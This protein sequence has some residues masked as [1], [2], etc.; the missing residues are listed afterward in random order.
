VSAA[1]LVLPPLSPVLVGRPYASVP[2]LAA[3]VD[4]HTGVRLGQRDLNRDFIMSLLRPDG[5]ALDVVDRDAAADDPAAVADRALR[6]AMID[7]IRMG[8]ATADTVAATARDIPFRR[9]LFAAAG[10]PPEDAPLELA[11]VLEL[12]ATARSPLLDFYRE[13]YADVGPLR[14][15][16]ISVPFPGQ[17]L[18]ALLLA[19]HLEA[20]GTDL[21]VMGGPTISLMPEASLERLLTASAVDAV[22]L[23]EG[24][25]ALARLVELGGHDA[26]LLATVPALVYRT[27][28]GVRRNPPGE[29]VTLAATRPHDL[30]GAYVRG[31]VEHPV[32]VGRGCMYECAFCD[33]IHLYD[34]VNFRPARDVVEAA[35]RVVEQTGNAACHF[36]FEV[37]T[38]PYLRL[39]A[40]SLVDA[41]V[42]CTWRGFQRVYGDLTHDDVRA[43][44]ASGCVRLDV[45]LESADGPTL[46]LMNKGYGVDEIERFFTAFQGSSI[47]LLVNIILDYPGLTFEA[48]VEA[49]E[50]LS[51]VTAQVP[52]VHFELMRYSLSVT[53]VMYEEP[54]R[55]GL[56]IRRADGSK[57]LAS[58]TTASF[59]AERGMSAAEVA[60][61]EAR[62]R[63]LNQD[64]RVRLAAAAAGDLER[65][66]REGVGRFVVGRRPFVVAQDP[67][68]ATT[69]L[70][71]NL[72]T[73]ET[74]A[75]DESLQGSLSALQRD[76]PI[77]GDVR[78]LP[79]LVGDDDPDVLR[80]LTEMGMVEPERRRPGTDGIRVGRA[81]DGAFYRG[82]SRRRDGVA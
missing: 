8:T 58:L 56:A 80:S 62:Y 68:D 53:S 7:A 17:L 47:Q 40:R 70:V 76:R 31:A 27:P 48:A 21:V 16:G 15:V 81:S 4:Q 77:R 50:T 12:A 5:P 60:E 9:W 39:L 44:E 42:R 46:S 65:A 52:D 3:Y 36:I 73:M 49:F 18:P 45:G 6:T 66:R 79:M 26:D 67:H 51:R 24:E 55:F 23:H 25:Q 14:L 82:V 59:D 34:E 11:A 63:R 43:L 38:L 74:F 57:V 64:K 2:H 72:Y 10:L 1:E 75:V 30:D 33:Y 19:R 29:R 28:A 69:L 41:G 61:V 37:L 54:E 22:V 13:V 78:D 35:A 71:R 20:C 32:M